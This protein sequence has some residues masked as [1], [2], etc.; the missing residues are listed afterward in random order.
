MDNIYI[1]DEMSNIPEAEI[2]PETE[3]LMV[4]YGEY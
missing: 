2:I 3:A 1:S 4:E